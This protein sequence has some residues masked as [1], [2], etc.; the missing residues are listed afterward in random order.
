MKDRQEMRTMTQTAVKMK[1]DLLFPQAHSTMYYLVP[2]PG[3]HATWTNWALQTDEGSPTA[4]TSVF[5]NAAYQEAAEPEKP[6]RDEW[7][8]LLPSGDD[9]SSRVDPTKLRNR[10]FNTGKGARAPQEKSGGIG[11]VWTETPE[12]KRKRLENEVMGVSK[13]ASQGGSR[14]SENILSTEDKE[15]AKRIQE[16]NEKYRNKSLYD[17]HSKSTTKEEEDDPSK[18]AFDREKDIAGGQKIGFT[19]KREMLNRA[20][21]F[22]SR[23]SGGR[24]L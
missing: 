13:P 10:K 17:E 24:Y 21:D 8:M 18:R 14:S 15:A 16:Y 7:M 1:L 12:Q 23:F 19:Q 20:K 6:Q 4:Q 2:L 11:S 5:D 3:F 22:G 9:W